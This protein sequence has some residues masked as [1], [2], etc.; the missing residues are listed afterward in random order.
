[1]RKIVEQGTPKEAVKNKNLGRV[2][3]DLQL[4]GSKKHLCSAL[5][6]LNS[7]Q[8]DRVKVALAEDDNPR[9][10][11]ELGHRHRSGEHCSLRCK[12]P[13]RGSGQ[14]G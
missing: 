5:C 14:T 10:R 3:F 12:G 2:G 1:M 9:L 8:L 7:G 6:R 11:K 4:L 13:R